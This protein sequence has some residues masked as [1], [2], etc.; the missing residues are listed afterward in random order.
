[1][2]QKHDRQRDLRCVGS[3]VAP[4]TPE[5]AGPGNSER[6]DQEAGG[7]VEVDRERNRYDYE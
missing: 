1:M 6:M 2:R 7:D 5:V 3:Y 4:D